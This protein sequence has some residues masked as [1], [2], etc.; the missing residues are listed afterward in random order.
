MRNGVVLALLVLSTQIRADGYSFVSGRFPDRNVTVFKLTTDQ[1]QFI[2][3]YWKCRD[4][5]FSPYI[6]QLSTEQSEALKAKT[7]TTVARFAIFQS[8]EGDTGVDLDFNVINRFSKD[9]F[10]VPH[11]L[12]VSETERIAWD[13]DIIGWKPNP[14]ANLT[15]EQLNA[16]K[17]PVEFKPHKAW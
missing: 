4:N 1:Q 14:L 2:E 16:N 11:R 17:C 9:E 15:S 5:R 3:F 6:F 8:I 7:G 13:Q 10:E 12:L